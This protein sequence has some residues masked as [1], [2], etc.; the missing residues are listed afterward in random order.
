MIGSS[1]CRD[2]PPRGTA[3]SACPPW[4]RARTPSRRSTPPRRGSTACLRTNRNRS[5]RPCRHRR[6][7]PP[8]HSRRPT[9]RCRPMRRASR[10]STCLF[11]TRPRRPRRQGAKP[12]CTP[13]SNVCSARRTRRSGTAAFRRA[14]AVGLGRCRTW[15]VKMSAPT[16]I[17][18][19]GPS[20]GIWT[21]CIPCAPRWVPI[22]SICS[23]RLRPRL[24]T[25]ALS[26]AVSPTLAC[27]VIGGS[28]SRSSTG[29]AGI[30]SPM[31]WD[32]TSASFTTVIRHLPSMGL[33]MHLPYAYGYSNA[34]NFSPI[35]GGQCWYTVMAYYKHC[36]DVPGG[37]G[38][39]APVL[40]FS[41]PYH[42]H[43]SSGEP[44][45]V[46]GELET[47]DVDGPADAARAL[48]RTRIRVAGY[49][50]RP[51]PPTVAGV[52]LAVPSGSVS[53]SPVV[54]NAGE[55]VSVRAL[56]ANIGAGFVNSSS[57][58]FWSQY[59]ESDAEWTRRA[60]KTVGGLSPGSSKTIMWR[61]TGGSSP[62]RGITESCGSGRE[63]GGVSF[64]T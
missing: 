21:M 43:P 11:C 62:G 29:S 10:R 61:G 26:H 51:D 30:R 64:T 45:G 49:Y 53:I 6:T 19:R 58:S 63:A 33:Q 15:R 40:S 44:L 17:A 54:V 1:P 28:E 4:A 52:D 25:T 39:I 56:V 50:R 37:R 35:G 38:F 3:P 14:S 7:L 16:S 41:S 59:D 22:S 57:V 18:C 31:N 47:L 42:R 46:L 34:E 8:R 23:L 20:T 55:S 36:F 32:T 60:S 27:A 24:R 5:I 48:D 9:R 2:P 12:A 13:R